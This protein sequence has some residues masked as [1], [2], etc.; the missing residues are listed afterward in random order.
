MN[1]NNFRFVETEKEENTKEKKARLRAE[2]KARRGETENRDTKEDA[3]V[4]AVGNAV[5]NAQVFFVYLSVSSEARTEKLI[6]TLLEKG[7]TVVCPR[8]HGGEMHAVIYGEDFTLSSFGVKEPIGA[9]YLGKIDVAIV[10]L[11]AVDEQGNRLG[12]GGGYYDRFLSEH[13]ECVRLG[14]GYES[15]KTA[16]LPVDA[17]D[18]PL[19]GFISENQTVWWKR[20][21]RENLQ[22]KYGENYE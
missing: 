6:E 3:I 11:L 1:I 10:P 21:G 13:T 5:F 2:W 4:K 9:E 16:S 20:S 8:V 14:I 19:D 17:W 15:Q 22:K 18:V 12:Y 7:K